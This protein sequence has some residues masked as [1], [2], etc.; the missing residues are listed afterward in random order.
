MKQKTKQSGGLSSRLHFPDDEKRLAWLA[1]LPD[2]YSISDTGVATTA[3]NTEEKKKRKICLRPGVRARLP[4]EDG[5]RH[6]ASYAAIG[7]LARSTQ[8][9]RWKISMIV[10]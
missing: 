1:L 3:R 6:Q 7:T 4:S 5:M 8:E 9:G 10:S 2:A